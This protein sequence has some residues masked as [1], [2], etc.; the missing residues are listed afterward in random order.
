MTIKG[1][2]AGTTYYYKVSYTNSAYAAYRPLY[3]FKTALAAGDETPYSIACYGDLGLMGHDGLSSRTGPL[4]GPTTQL[5][6]NETN[7]IQSLLQQSDSY[8]FIIHA[9]DI[10]Y[11]DYFLK[12]AIQG[13]FNVSTYNDTNIPDQETVAE[14]YESLSEQFFDQLQP[15][16]AQ[17]P[18]MVSAGNHEANCNNG[19]YSPKKPYASNKIDASYCLEGQRNFT[20]YRE[21]YRMPSAESGGEENFWYSYDYGLVHF[22]ALHTET[23]LGN[24]LGGPIQNKTGNMVSRKGARGTR[25]NKEKA[26]MYAA[27]PER[28]FWR[29]NELSNRLAQARSGQ[30]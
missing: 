15:V 30:R 9:G 19:G 24:G 18:W 7:T 21:H 12:E 28:S 5:G 2:A 8:A 17:R 29:P 1:L 4:G 27:Q 10:G 16:T 20:F 3:T 22:V 13:Y 26:H 14:R 23:D 11:A 25:A 6:P